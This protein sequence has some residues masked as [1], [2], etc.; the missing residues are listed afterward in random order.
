VVAAGADTLVVGSA[1]YAPDVD[2]ADA[3]RALR[4]AVRGAPERSQ[5]E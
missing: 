1:V 3:L 4:D 2:I 5:A